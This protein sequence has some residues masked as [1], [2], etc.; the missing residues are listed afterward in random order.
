MPKES[1][2]TSS[3]W[4]GPTPHAWP[5]R[6][7]LVSSP[8]GPP[9]SQCPHPRAGR[10]TGA[11][12]SPARNGGSD[13]RE[14]RGTLARP[15]P[16][17]AVAFGDIGGAPGGD[18]PSQC[19]APGNTVASCPQPRTRWDPE[20]HPEEKGGPQQPP[21]EEEGGDAAGGARGA[22]AVMEQKPGGCGTRSSPAG[23]RRFGFSWD[24][25]LPT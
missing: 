4:A 17:G 3:L 24:F 8:S 16:P 9:V 1:P 2:T 13:P 10:A 19:L 20:R 25:G 22:L 7:A 12:L 23:M 5:W 18:T 15:P 14:G 11:G 6:G 21:E